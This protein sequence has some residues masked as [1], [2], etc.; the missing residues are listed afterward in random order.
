MIKFKHYFLLML[1]SL[2][3]IASHAYDFEVDG[4]YYNLISASDKTC[5]LVGGN[6]NLTQ[7]TIPNAITVRNQNLSVVS[8]SSY[9]FKNKT[10]AVSVSFRE[11]VITEIPSNAFYAC[12]QLSSVVLSSKIVT[13]SSAAFYNCPI[14][15]LT[16][17][18][19][20]DKVGDNAL[21]SVK[22]LII[23]DSNTALN[24]VGTTPAIE[25]LYLGRD[26]T[27]AIVQSSSLG[28]VQIGPK[29]TTLPANFF[30]NC[31]KLNVAEIPSNVKTIGNYCFYG[32]SLI[33]K[34][35]I[36]NSES[37]GQYAFA[38]CNNLR[39]ADINAETI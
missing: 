26:V 38:N 10:N 31:T 20:V 29:V 22:E 21:N 9:A 2:C 4:L 5:E 27:S 13:I 30:R 12:T 19:N 15:K 14:Q 11:S 37:I 17:P 6:D 8:M 32:C 16:I 36:S 33:K 35:T 3:S 34:V 7:I 28:K 39:M 25:K 23:E 18:S 1:L 24:I